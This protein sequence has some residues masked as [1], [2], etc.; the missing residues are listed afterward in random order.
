MRLS[1]FSLWIY[2]QA[3][4]YKM[5]GFIRHSQRPQTPCVHGFIFFWNLNIKI[6]IRGL[7]LA[8][9]GGDQATAKPWLNV[10]KR[11]ASTGTASASEFV[12]SLNLNIKIGNCGLFLSRLGGDQATAKP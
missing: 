1:H 4:V 5:A 6:G 2:P 9:L 7:F 10:K 11:L 3:C 8:G 12:S